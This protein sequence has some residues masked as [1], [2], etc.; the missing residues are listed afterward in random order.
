MPV[1]TECAAALLSFR[2]AS[3]NLCMVLL[4]AVQ[5][6]RDTISKRPRGEE[7]ENKHGLTT[8]VLLS[9]EILSRPATSPPGKLYCTT[10]LA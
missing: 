6:E 3:H 10:H 4:A 7:T 8:S 2:Y 5:N 1:S 9:A